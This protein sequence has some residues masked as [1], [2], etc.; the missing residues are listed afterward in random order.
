M[1]NEITL[2]KLYKMA[3]NEESLTTKGLLSL[4]FN[5]VDLTKL[6]KD[7][8]LE[9]IQRGIYEFKSDALLFH[10]GKKLMGEQNYS[11]GISCF[12]KSLE[13]NP[14]NTG[15]AYQLFK[16]AI[17]ECDYRQA[18][19]YFEVCGLYDID[20]REYNPKNKLLLYLFSMLIEVPEEYISYV[21]GISM[22]DLTIRETD[23]RYNNIE[24]ENKIR[25]LVLNGEYIKAMMLIDQLRKDGKSINDVD[26][27][28]KSLLV[29][30]NKNNSNRLNHFKQ[31]IEN[32]DYSLVIHELVDIKKKRNL[33]PFEERILDM[34]CDLF[35]IMAAE[36]LPIV[37]DVRITTLDDA[38]KAKNYKLALEMYNDSVVD[39][40][41]LT[42]QDKIL[43]LLLVQLNKEVDFSK[44]EIDENSEQMLYANIIRAFVDS[45]LENVFDLLDK[46]L[47]LINKENYK[48]LIVDLAKI[49][50]LEKDLTFSKPI[51]TLTTVGKDDFSIDT[52]AYLKDFYQSLANGKLEQAEVYLDI[53]NKAETLDRI[54]I[55]VDSLN[56]VFNNMKVVMSDEH[57]RKLD[58]SDLVIPVSENKDNNIITPV[59]DE[60]P[61]KT[62]VDDAVINENVI[63]QY[64]DKINDKG[65]IILDVND[66]SY[67]EVVARGQVYE[68]FIG[69]GNNKKR[70]LR[71]Y[72]VENW[73]YLDY[74]MI[75]NDASSLYNEGC[76]VAAIKL[77]KELF[78]T[79]DLNSYI[80][81]KLGLAYAKLWDIE[82]A[83]DYLSVATELS[84]KE[85]KEYNYSDIIAGLRGNIE[86]PDNEPIKPVVRMKESDFKQDC[87][88]DYTIPNREEIDTLLTQGVS[89][90]IILNSFNFNDEQRGLVKLHMAKTY[91]GMQIDSLGDR[92]LGEVERAK[93]KTPLIKD[94]YSEVKKNRK[95]YKYRKND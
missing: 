6:V 18:F 25:K 58:G 74:K 21:K 51:I 88:V 48:F 16:K 77:Y 39:N 44:E 34:A 26:M 92:F 1:I 90:D 27:M 45:D 85:G 40:G 42:L 68:F 20:V 41:N 24:D 72:P 46:Y 65:L 87:G 30:V 12:E 94:L 11:Q 84:K 49:S 32:G 35:D 62:E 80:Y 43:K 38:I 83:V 81:S 31:L 61:D 19:N 54:G 63:K 22:E 56:N 13:M 50:I 59:I 64:I 5:S 71:Y 93:G 17:R 2:E 36:Q 89:P 60:Y 55:D 23:T 69:E 52:V 10:Y 75:M 78:Q 53:I 7:G 15:A 47:P 3:L 82:T 4:G 73:D 79:P 76:Y 86:M 37:Q 91:Y 67:K 14:N 28:V 57:E 29:V 66:A 70:V 9:R 95:F 33:N 8:T